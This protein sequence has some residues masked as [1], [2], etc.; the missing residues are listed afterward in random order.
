MKVSFL[1]KGSNHF[2]RA[3]PAGA[4]RGVKAQ[5]IDVTAQKNKNEPTPKSIPMFLAKT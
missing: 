3:W 5:E 1:S 4:S 2:C